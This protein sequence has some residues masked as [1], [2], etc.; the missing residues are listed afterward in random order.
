[1]T[2]VSVVALVETKEERYTM[3]KLTCTCG[4][5]LWTAVFVE[6]QPH[7]AQVRNSLLPNAP[8]SFVPQVLRA[9]WQ[10]ARC[11][12]VQEAQPQTVELPEPP[13]TED[14]GTP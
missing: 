13:N 7:Q 2:P 8:A 4:H 11:G 3:S 5:T 10:C 12:L 14:D 6:I 9:M 1:M